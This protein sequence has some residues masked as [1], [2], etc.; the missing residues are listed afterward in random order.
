MHAFGHFMQSWKQQ[1]NRQWSWHIGKCS[2]SEHIST[3]FEVSPST[4]FIIWNTY[5][6]AFDAFDAQRDNYFIKLRY[7]LNNRSLVMEHA[8][9]NIYNL[10]AL[11]GPDRMNIQASDDLKQNVAST[12]ASNTLNGMA[13]KIQD[14]WAWIDC[15]DYWPS[16]YITI[17]VLG[18]HPMHVLSLLPFWICIITLQSQ[19][20]PCNWRW[21]VQVCK[22]VG[23]QFIS[24]NSGVSALIPNKLR[25]EGI[26]RSDLVLWIF[27]SLHAGKSFLRIP[28]FLIFVVLM[29]IGTLQMDVMHFLPCYKWTICCNLAKLQW[30]LSKITISLQNLI[31]PI[32]DYSC[33]EWKVHIP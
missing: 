33:R 21:S 23:N 30:D 6:S 31:V 2:K 15:Y 25:Q 12:L 20:E 24:T 29:R 8:C 19:G 9:C 1:Y 17:H 14:L 32:K 28:F 26:Y 4:V 3:E 11:A 10:K 18:R 5:T 16:T 22:D 7:S 27:Y 13:L